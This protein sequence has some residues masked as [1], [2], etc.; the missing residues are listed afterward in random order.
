MLVSIAAIE[1]D[2]HLQQQVNPV[3]QLRGEKPGPL[4]SE[5]TFHHCCAL[6]WWENIPDSSGQSVLWLLWE[7]DI[8]V[9]RTLLGW[10]V[11]NCFSLWG[12]I[13]RFFIDELQTKLEN[14]LNTFFFHSTWQEGLK[15]LL[16]CTVKCFN[17]TRKD[18]QLPWPGLQLLR[19][20]VAINLL[21]LQV[22][23]EPLNEP[24]HLLQ[25]CLSSWIF[26]VVSC[27]NSWVVQCLIL[28]ISQIKF[29]KWP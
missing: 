3:N 4:G 12:H 11:P 14:H 15:K 2:L 17:L 23:P 13:F 19:G 25:D 7:S 24:Q 1:S 20:A 26:G 16:G 8:I 27:R 18:V 9:S 5:E 21:S 28:T 10:L 29:L 6:G 22:I